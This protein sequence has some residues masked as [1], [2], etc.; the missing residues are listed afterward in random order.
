M[1][2]LPIFSGDEIEWVSLITTISVFR[3][4]SNNLNRGS[5]FKEKKTGTANNIGKTKSVLIYQFLR[6]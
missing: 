1:C 5:K 2:I 3:S 4:A 6:P